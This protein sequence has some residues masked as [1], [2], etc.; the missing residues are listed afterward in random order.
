H[1]VRRD[2]GRR[3]YFPDRQFD[4]GLRR[5][6]PERRSVQAADQGPVRARSGWMARQRQGFLGSTMASH[7]PERIAGFSLI[8]VLVAAAVL[9]IGLLA[10]VSLQ[11]SLIRSSS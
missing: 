9:S 1:G 11:A 10:L 3:Q 2:H 4:P 8:E 5:H 6:V 7:P